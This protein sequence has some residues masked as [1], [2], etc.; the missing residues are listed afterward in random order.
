MQLSQ[1]I[2]TCR[3]KAGLS[4]EALA[5]KLGVSRQAVSKWETGESEPEIGKLKLLAQ[6]FGVTVDWLLSEEEEPQKNPEISRN[7]P[8]PEWLDH[9]PRFLSSLAK[10]YGWLAGIIISVWG[11]FCTLIGVMAR[12]SIRKMMDFGDSFGAVVP[13]LSDNPVYLF[14][15]VFLILGIV[16]MLVG[17]CLA[18]YLKKKFRK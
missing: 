9:L 13:A 7:S 18:I 16:V 10:R 8:S 2:Y 14:G 3:K 15:T 17:I 12:V 5:E 6:T 1:K 11:F 4:Q